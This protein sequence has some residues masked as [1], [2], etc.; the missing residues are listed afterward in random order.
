M[1]AFEHLDEV[2]LLEGAVAAESLLPRL[3]AV[4]DLDDVPLLSELIAVLIGPL[5]EAPELR[6]RAARF[7]MIEAV[8]AAFLLHVLEVEVRITAERRDH[9][10]DQLARVAGVFVSDVGGRG[11]GGRRRN[12]SRSLG[13]NR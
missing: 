11:W 10:V 9:L 4:V 1:A 7:A 5:P 12:R 13:T 8:G 2:F 6:A 3:V